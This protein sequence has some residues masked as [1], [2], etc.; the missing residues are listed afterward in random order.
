MLPAVHLLRRAALVAIA[1]AVPPFLIGNALLVLAHPWTADAAYA[2]PGFPDPRID[3]GEGE[4]SRLA[5]VGVRAIQPW[6]A[7]GIEAMAQ[8]RLD[9]GRRAFIAA[10]RRHFEDV[11]NLVALFLSAWAAAVLVILAAAGLGRDRSVLRGGLRAGL[12][13][14]LGAFVLTSFL[15]V[16]GFSAFFEGIHAILFEGDTWRLP[17]RGTARSLYPDAFWRLM[18][19][20]MAALVLAQVAAIVAVMG[21]QMRRGDGDAAAGALA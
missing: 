20:A 4:R 13:L 9:D 11:R 8:T 10:E 1:L 19:G 17:K 2:L 6:R 15:M 21:P 16:V 18:G 14:A 12:Y 5:A 7:G 3:L